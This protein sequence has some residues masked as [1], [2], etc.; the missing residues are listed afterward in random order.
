MTACSKLKLKFNALKYSVG[1]KRDKKPKEPKEP[2]E[3]DDEEP[4]S[5]VKAQG[6][7]RP[8][9]PKGKKFRILFRK[10]HR[11]K[12]MNLRSLD[13]CTEKVVES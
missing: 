5:E 10:Y 13:F 1:N 6:N 11:Y 9:K 8:K 3:P 12:N 4:D 2:D 7:K